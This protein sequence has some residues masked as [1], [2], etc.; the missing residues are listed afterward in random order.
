MMCVCVFR[1][2]VFSAPTGLTSS[3]DDD[4]EDVNEDVYSDDDYQL[5]IMH[6]IIY[7]GPQFV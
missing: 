1:R 7:C 5:R 6:I 4:D 3:D 2:R